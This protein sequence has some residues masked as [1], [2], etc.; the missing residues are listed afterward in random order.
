MAHE[1]ARTKA[2]LHLLR[3]ARA[4]SALA[5]TEAQLALAKNNLKRIE[6]LLAKQVVTVEQ[7]DQVRTGA[8]VGFGRDL[9]R[10]V[11][12]CPLRRSGGARRRG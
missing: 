2:A 10:A 11:F 7:G 4:R 6:P 8:N 1:H 9:S 3:R 5:N 12:L